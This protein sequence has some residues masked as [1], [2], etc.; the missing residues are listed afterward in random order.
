MK[1]IFVLLVALF[2]TGCEMAMQNSAPAPVPVKETATVSKSLVDIDKVHT[3][4][5]VEEVKKILGDEILVGYELIDEKTSGYKSIVVK[6]P[7]RAETIEQGTDVYD[8]L[9]YFTEVKK[10][11]GVISDEE[12][13]PLTFKLG[14]LVGSDR[15]F[16]FKLKNAKTTTP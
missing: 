9:Y 11:D 13:T 6:N 8:V 10:P 15:D 2:L 1:K 16:L 3:G 4:M 7:V 14:K 12:L 5:T